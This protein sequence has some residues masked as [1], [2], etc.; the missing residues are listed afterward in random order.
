MPAARLWRR[1]VRHHEKARAE[2]EESLRLDT[3]KLLTEARA[4]AFALHANNELP[5]TRSEAKQKKP[6]W[7]KIEKSRE[8]LLEFMQKFQSGISSPYAFAEYMNLPQVFEPPKQV[9]KGTKEYKQK[10]R[11]EVRAREARISEALGRI[12]EQTGNAAFDQ[13]MPIPATN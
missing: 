11:E 3:L 12:A 1:I 2:Y 10:I 6:N 4:I 13:A 8:E 9:Q 7:G 5:P